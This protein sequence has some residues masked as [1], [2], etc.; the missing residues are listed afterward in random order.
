MTEQDAKTDAQLHA[1]AVQ[2]VKQAEAKI[3]AIIEQAEVQSAI[4]VANSDDVNGGKQEAAQ[5]L[6]DAR[7]RAQDIAGRAI[8]QVNELMQQADD[9]DEAKRLTA[10]LHAA[11]D[12]PRPGIRFSDQIEAAR[13]HEVEGLEAAT[14]RTEAALNA[15]MLPFLDHLEHD[16][17]DLEKPVVEDADEKHD[18]A[19]HSDTVT[20]PRVGKVTVPG[21]LY[22]VVFVVLAV[23]T[24]VE[25]LLAESPL[26]NVIAFPLL[27]ALSIGKAVLVVLYYMH[28][29]EDSRIFAW[30]F[31]LPLG[32]AGMIIIFL[33]IMNPF[34]Y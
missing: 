16:I 28:L 12:E 22:T 27:A 18:H 8:E 11:I 1:E 2:T 26:P 23:V 25:V 5:V 13:D 4:D 29:M 33:L 30:A 34:A 10:A 15:V 24:I 7:A 6:A 19:L 14:L 20:L 31:G 17:E 32:M 3:D 21:G 9:P